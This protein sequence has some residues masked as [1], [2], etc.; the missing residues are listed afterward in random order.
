MTETTYEK[1]NIITKDLFPSVT[2][3]DILHWENKRLMYKG[4]QVSRETLASLSS[5]AKAIKSFDLYKILTDEIKFLA[6]KKLFEDT[7]TV[8]DLKI[9]R[10]ILWTIDVLEKKMDK[11]S[12]M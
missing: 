5:Q 11:I 10:M 9:A 3:D 7:Q 12:Q 8:E 6:Q 1:I 2:Q 4:Q